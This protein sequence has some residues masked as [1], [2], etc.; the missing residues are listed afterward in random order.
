[1]MSMESEGLHAHAVALVRHGR[2]ILRGVSVT[3]RA[4]ELVAVIGENGAGKSSLLKVMAGELRPDGGSV[5]LDGRLMTALGARALARRR[6]VLPQDLALGFDFEAL[7]VVLL[8]RYPHTGGGE[9]SAERAF[10]MHCLALTECAHLAHQRTTTLS[11]GERARVQLARVLAQLGR[12]GEGGRYALLDEP[13][14]SLDLSHQLAL[15]E[16]LARLTRESSI[17]VLVTVHDL[18]LAMRYADRIVVLRGGSVVGETPG[19]LD[20]ELIRTAFGVEAEV[21]RH[22]QVRHCMVALN[23]VAHPGAG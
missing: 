5:S 23:R 11:G 8:G 2:R 19:S 20:E 15:F 6:A 14:A 9:S 21:R 13:A 10:A 7:E 3:V 1:M 18:G 16:L 22:P 12:E 17:G 4:G